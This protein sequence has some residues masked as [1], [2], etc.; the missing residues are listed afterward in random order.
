MREGVNV[1]SNW[2]NEN[3][4]LKCI[5]PTGGTTVLLKYNLDIPSREFCRNL[6]KAT[7]VALLPGETLEMEGYVRLGFCAE[8]LKPA[9]KKISEYVVSLS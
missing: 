8:N 5:L 7:G 3:P 6:Q 1:L 4:K 9:L 2:L